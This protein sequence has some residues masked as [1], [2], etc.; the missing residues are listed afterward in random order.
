MPLT[1]LLVALAVV[2]VWGTNFTVSKLGLATWPPLLFTA[3]RFGF[4]ALPALFLPRPQVSWKTLTI[5]GLL[6]G[7][8]MFALMFTAMQGDI[9]P[10][11]ASLVVQT[12]VFFTIGLSAAFQ[13]ERVARLQ[14]LALAIAVTGI[15][16]IGWNVTSSASGTVVT[17]RGLFLVLGA[18]LSWALTNIVVK[19]TGKLDILPFMAWSSIPPAIALFALSFAVEGGRWAEAFTSAGPGAWSAAIWQ[20]VGNTLFGYGAWSWLLA[21]HPASHVAPTALLVPVFGM[22][23]SALVLAEPLPLWKIAAAALVIGGLALNILASRR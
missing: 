6:M 19:R 22:G 16:L 9:T 21:R 23:T 14:M 4:S 7:P 3:L 12:Q 18:A 20:A 17:W 15:L 10:G 8:G 11:L 1:H 5:Y 13:G 2:A